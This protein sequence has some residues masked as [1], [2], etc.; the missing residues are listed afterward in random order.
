M[1]GQLGVFREFCGYL[2]G[3][4]F[5]ILGIG[6][7]GIGW[8]GLSDQFG[9]RIALITVAAGAVSRINFPL[10][11]GLFLFAQNSW[12]LSNLEALGFAAPG[13]LLLLPSITAEVFS[14]LMGSAT[15][16]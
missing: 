10:L 6:L 16:R 7:C 15:R 12:G 3:L 2:L 1:E 8:I 4:A 14:I 11:I 9:W 13:L 5:V